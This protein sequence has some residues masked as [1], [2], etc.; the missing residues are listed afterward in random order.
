MALNGSEAPAG[1][2]PPRDPPSADPPRDPPLTNGSHPGTP[3]RGRDRPRALR[4]LPGTPRP[5]PGHSRDPPPDLGGAPPLNPP[6]PR[7]GTPLGADEAEARRE[8]LD[9][10]SQAMGGLLL[11]GYRMLGSCCPSTILLQDK[12]Q[13]LL[14]V[15]C[16]DPGG[17][18][19]PPPAPSPAAPRP[20]HCEGAAAAFRG[21]PPAPPEPPGAAV[22]AARAAVLQKLLWA[23]Q[24]LPR[25]SSAEGS[26]QLCRL[27]RACAD[28]LGGLQ[29]L[30]PPRG[31]AQ[32]PPTP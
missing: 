10:A 26:A 4:I 24:E 12:E 25:T 3:T 2:P 15:T 5:P 9:R 30:E 6:S 17:G 13:R 14:C 27:V 7:F 20:E 29:A 18:H 23:A 31:A 21:A 28:A 19:A 8:R 1:P 32:P 16:Q 22:A 11:R